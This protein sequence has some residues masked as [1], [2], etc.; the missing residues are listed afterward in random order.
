LLSA[1]ADLPDPES[2]SFTRSML[3]RLF[4][5]EPDSTRV[6]AVLHFVDGL[7]LEETA[8]EVGLSVS[9]VRKRLRTLKE[10][11]GAL[12]PEGSLT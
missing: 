3:S 8:H 11:L 2:T 6:M 9:G 7:T 5:R 10:R 12:A 4:A 1:I